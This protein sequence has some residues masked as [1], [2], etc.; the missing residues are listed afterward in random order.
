[1]LNR[2][3]AP[4]P[5]LEFFRDHLVTFSSGV[6][7]IWQGIRQILSSDPALGKGE[8]VCQIYPFHVHLRFVLCMQVNSDP[9]WESTTK[10]KQYR[11]QTETPHLW[12]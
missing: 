4:A 9:S 1:M 11:A 8:I 7:T 10:K 6:P 5:T 3:L 2:F 12:W